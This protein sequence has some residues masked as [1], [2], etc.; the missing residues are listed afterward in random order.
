M[1]RD[2][3]RRLFEALLSSADRETLLVLNPLLACLV[4]ASERT[5]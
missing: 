5:R 4:G 3:A 1:F 2:Q